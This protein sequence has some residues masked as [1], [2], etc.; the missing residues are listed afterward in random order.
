MEPCTRLRELGMKHVRGCRRRRQVRRGGRDFTSFERREAD[1][2]V[3][4]EDDPIDMRNILHRDGSVL[5]AVTPAQ[6]ASEDP[7]YRDLGA[8]LAVRQ[9]L[10]DIATSDSV[11][12]REIRRRGR[13]GRA[14]SAACKRSAWAWWRP[15]PRSRRPPSTTPSPR[16]QLKE[17]KGDMA[18]PK[19]AVRWAVVFDGTTR[20]TRRSRRRSRARP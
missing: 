19:G 18:M 7:F 3:Q 20:P 15:S 5:S 6:L 4:K 8:K 13:R 2:P 10:R 14:R 16:C 11:F 1:L 17:A 12:L 9:A